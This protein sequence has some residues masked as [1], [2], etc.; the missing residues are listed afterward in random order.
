MTMEL[1]SGSLVKQHFTKLHQKY[2]RKFKQ[3]AM[4]LM[5]IDLE[6]MNSMKPEISPVVI[7]ETL[8]MGGDD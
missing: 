1:L 6:K 4:K 5:N 8:S 3:Y 7:Q 2:W